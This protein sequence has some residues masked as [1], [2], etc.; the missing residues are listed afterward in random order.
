MTKGADDTVDM[1]NE[2]NNLEKTPIQ[3]VS[4]LTS[5]IISPDIHRDKIQAFEDQKDYLDLELGMLL[6]LYP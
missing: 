4:V 2:T 1:L 3:D 5:D 6:Y